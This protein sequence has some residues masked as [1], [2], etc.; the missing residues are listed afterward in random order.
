MQLHTSDRE[1]DAPQMDR[2]LRI[3]TQGLP[4]NNV[5]ACATCHAGGAREDYPVLIG[6]HP[7]YIVQ[8]LELW[9]RGK[10]ANTPSERIMKPIAERL[11]A[12]D[13]RD[14]AVYF[15]SLGVRSQDSAG[16]E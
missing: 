14:V 13:M 11:G 10:R 16:T 15:G 8:Q 7:D 3:A 4:E 2:G 1:P 6:Q 12:Q 9:Q 5:P